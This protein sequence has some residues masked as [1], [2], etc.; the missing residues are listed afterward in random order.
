ML[1]ILRDEPGLFV[2]RRRLRRNEASNRLTPNQRSALLSMTAPCP[3]A[4]NG[5][6]GI[7]AEECCSVGSIPPPPVSTVSLLQVHPIRAR[8]SDSSKRIPASRTR[9]RPKPSWRYSYPGCA[10]SNSPCTCRPRVSCSSDFVFE[11]APVRLFARP[12][13]SG[14][15]LGGPRLLTFWQSLVES[16]RCTCGGPTSPVLAFSGCP[17]PGE[18]WRVSYNDD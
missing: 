9:R 11:R 17:E 15:A 6:V 10:L 5:S 7:V 13:V 2:F 8:L 14:M 16:P 4:L 3:I 12:Q 1:V 18:A